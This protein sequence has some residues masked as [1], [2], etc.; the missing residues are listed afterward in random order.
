MVGYGVPLARRSVISEF[1]GPYRFLS[2]FWIEPDGTCVEVEYQQ[3]KTD[4]P[5]NFSGM[6]PGQAKRAGI[7]AKLRPD[8][9][10]IKVGIMIGLVRR[11]F[12][13]HP[14]LAAKLISTGSEQLIEGNRWGDRFWGVCG[15]SGLN[16]LGEILMK[17]R[18][19]VS[20]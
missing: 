17:V 12:S 15:G 19:E 6:T 10:S 3:S 14:S 4:P 16:K 8:W 7:R 9:N 5:S 2:N 11:K 1:Q 13:D 18:E 20:R